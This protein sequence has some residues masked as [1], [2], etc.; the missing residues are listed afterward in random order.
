MPHRVAA[1]AA[2]RAAPDRA[3]ATL[4]R[5]P[6]AAPAAPSSASAF[7]AF[8]YAPPRPSEYGSATMPMRRVIRSD[9]A[10]SIAVPSSARLRAGMFSAAGAASRP[11]PPAAIAPEPVKTNGISG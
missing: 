8:M 11:R 7:P 6:S 9:A 1:E 10:T 2:S 3:A 4:L 5:R